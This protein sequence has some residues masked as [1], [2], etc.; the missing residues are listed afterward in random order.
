[1]PGPLFIM[2]SREKQFKSILTD[3]HE[4]IFRI[5]CYYLKNVE[6]RKDLFQE[7]LYN[8]W[9]S[10][11][12]FCGEAAIDTWVYRIALNTALGYINKEHKRKSDILEIDLQFNPKILNEDDQEQRERL[13]KLTEELHTKLNQLSVIDKAIMTLLLEELSTREIANI[14]GIT[15]PNVRVIIH[16]IKNLMKLEMK[17]YNYET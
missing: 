1:M 14:V 12:N 11:K 6:D 4:K 5:C 9:K 16:R 17:G 3:N 13:E 10:L 15:E 2:H 8:I 7:I